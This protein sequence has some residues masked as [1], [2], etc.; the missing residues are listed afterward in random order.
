MI[1]YISVHVFVVAYKQKQTFY[2]SICSPV[3]QVT[4]VLVPVKASSPA[5]S[6]TTSR[7]SKHTYKHTHIQSTNTQAHSSHSEKVA[8]LCSCSSTVAA[9]VFSSDFQRFY[10]KAAG[11][12]RRRW[13]NW[14]IYTGIFKNILYPIQ[15][16][17]S[18]KTPLILI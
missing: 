15:K 2:L 13:G 17:L 10:A 6:S 16:Q 14:W 7:Y 4:P 1:V 11:G 3:D 9:A 18:G 5:P 8:L 12:Q